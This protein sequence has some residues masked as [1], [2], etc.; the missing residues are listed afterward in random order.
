MKKEKILRPSYLKGLGG[1]A[2]GGFI[3]FLMWIMVA[4]FVGGNLHLS[5]GFVLALFLYY[6]YFPWEAK[7]PRDSMPFFCP[8]CF[9]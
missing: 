7:R 4:H 2:L 8:C 6:G 5:F 3:A 1:A 9:A